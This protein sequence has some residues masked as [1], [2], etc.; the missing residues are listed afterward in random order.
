MRLCQEHLLKQF[1]SF[2]KDSNYA[3]NNVVEMNVVQEP[4]YNSDTVL[5]TKGL[6][7]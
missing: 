2:F 4:R 1:L 6:E 3:P 5:L 7:A